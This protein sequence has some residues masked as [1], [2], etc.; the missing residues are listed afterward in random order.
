MLQCA[1]INL[2]IVLFDW[3]LLSLMSF[4]VPID[5]QCLAVGIAAVLILLSGFID[6]K[7]ITKTTAGQLCYTSSFFY[8]CPILFCITV[9]RKKW[10]NIV[11]CHRHKSK[12]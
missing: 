1:L 6:L 3:I 4:T 8:A 2:S 7:I 12:R 10:E 5:C 9:S 11:S